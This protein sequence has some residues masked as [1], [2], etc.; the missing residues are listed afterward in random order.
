MISTYELG[1][2][3]LASGRCAYSVTHD[4]IFEPVR[5]Y[6]YR[7]SA[8]HS[9]TFEDE[10][11]REVPWRAWWPSPD[12]IGF[13]DFTRLR[14]PGW[15]GNLF[16]CFYCMSFWTAVFWILMYLTLG[17]WAMW[18]AVVPAMWAI[19]NLYAKVISA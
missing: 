16:S 14:E 6:V 15:W 13:V 8:P 5:A 1:V 19:G 10:D 3:A 12:G 9:D 4:T 7:R 2:L 17:N 18:I 11:G